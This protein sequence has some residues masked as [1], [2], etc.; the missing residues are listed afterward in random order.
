MLSLFHN[1]IYYSI[2]FCLLFKYSVLVFRKKDRMPVIYLNIAS[3]T[4]IHIANFSHFTLSLFRPRISE[5]SLK[6]IRKIR[7]FGTTVKAH[8]HREPSI[9]M[10]VSK[11]LKFST[12]LFSYANHASLQVISLI[13]N[14]HRI[15]AA[16]VVFFPLLYLLPTKSPG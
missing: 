15:D 4:E 1:K 9:A 6:F 5:N 2:S 13:E 3:A 7:N 10:F 14:P 16:Y 11:L 12:F 8:R